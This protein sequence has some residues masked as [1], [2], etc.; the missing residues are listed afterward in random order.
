MTTTVDIP[1]NG[2]RTPEQEA[3]LT[4]YPIMHGLARIDFMSEQAVASLLSQ[5]IQAKFDKFVQD[6]LLAIVAY[7]ETRD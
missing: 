5:I 7:L 6:R 3:A 1:L 4:L 2:D